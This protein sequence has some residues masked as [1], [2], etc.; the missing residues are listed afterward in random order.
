L[1]IFAYI[2]CAVFTDSSAMG[3]ILARSPHRL[4]RVAGEEIGR[5]DS[6]QEVSPL[7]GHR[8]VA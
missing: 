3:Y 4:R 5:K 1:G 6:L 7:H 2:A 8:L